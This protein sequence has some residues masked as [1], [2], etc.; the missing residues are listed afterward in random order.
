[1]AK[2]SA[3]KQIDITDPDSWPF[4]MTCP[5][6]ATILGVSHTKIYDLAKRGEFPTI[7]LGGNVR[8]TKEVFINWL[9]KQN[10]V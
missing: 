2:K 4:I 6:V 5:Q 8:V 1:M 9:N 3:S 7:R 10:K